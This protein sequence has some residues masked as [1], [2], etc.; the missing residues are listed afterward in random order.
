MP[1]SVWPENT[2]LEAMASGALDELAEPLSRLGRRWAESPNR[3]HPERAA[4][5]LGLIGGPCWNR[6]NDH[7]IKSQ[8]LY[9]LS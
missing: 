1:E 5:R 9:Q 6:T 7:L 2:A 8:M 3:P 4:L